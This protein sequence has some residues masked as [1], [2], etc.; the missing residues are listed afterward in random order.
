MENNWIWILV[1]LYYVDEEA[2]EFS[3]QGLTAGIS[4]TAIVT[5]AIAAG[6][7]VLLISRRKKIAKAIMERL[8]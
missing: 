1:K 2:S 5:I 6:I 8:R 7:V 3:L 4:V